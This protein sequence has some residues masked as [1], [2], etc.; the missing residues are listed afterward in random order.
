MI[1]R[2]LQAVPKVHHNLTQP[3]IIPNSLQG[4]MVA[5]YR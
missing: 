3:I 5:Q 2:L 1:A 4:I